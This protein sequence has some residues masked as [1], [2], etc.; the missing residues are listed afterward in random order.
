MEFSSKINWKIKKRKKKCLND[1]VEII[2]LHWKK[3]ETV[4]EK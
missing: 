4:K 2:N 1:W 3:T